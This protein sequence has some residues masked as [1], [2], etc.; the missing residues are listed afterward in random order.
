MP[1]FRIVD[2]SLLIEAD[3]R[4]VLG[5]LEADLRSNPTAVV[6]PRVY[7]ETVTEP[8]S[9]GFDA[10]AT[11]IEKLF[12]SGVLRVEPPDY[13][14]SE[15]SDIVDRIRV[16]IA[17][18][19]GKPAHLVERADLQIVA[20]AVSHAKRGDSVELIFRDN[21]LKTCLDAVLRR[22]HV[23]NVSVTDFEQLVGQLSRRARIKR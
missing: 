22:L 20:L 6:P 8:K 7:E 11:R 10:S 21:V 5:A 13:T 16:C 2:S 15:V 23:S 17:T 4:R 18:R 14:D 3:R 19:A 9:A 1:R 12:K